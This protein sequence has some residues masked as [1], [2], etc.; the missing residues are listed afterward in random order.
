MKL[1][2]RLIRITIVALALLAAGCSGSGS[3]SSASSESSEAGQAVAVE[4]S[5]SEKSEGD[6]AGLVDIGGG[7]KMY[8]ECRGKG[9]PTVVLVSGLGNAADV[10]SVTSDPENERPAVFAEVATFTRVCAYDRPSTRR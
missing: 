10:W 1:S 9:G 6:F 2:I 7:R 3:D 4:E 5:E 8:M